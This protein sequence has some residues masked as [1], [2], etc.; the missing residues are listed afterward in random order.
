MHP[1]STCA[2]WK[3]L[4]QAQKESKVTCKIHP[5]DRRHVTAA[6]A[7]KNSGK[8][9][10]RSCK[11]LGHHSL[12]CPTKFAQT[13]TGSATPKTMTSATNL[14]PVLLQTALLSGE[15][16]AKHGVMFDL[17]STDDYVTHELTKRLGFEGVHV[18]LIVEGIAGNK[19]S[20]STMIYTV[21]IRDLSGTFHTIQCYGLNN[22]CTSAAPPRRQVWLETWSGAEAR[23][24]RH[25]S[26][27]EAEQTAPSS[28]QIGREDDTVSRCVWFCVRRFRQKYQF[29]IS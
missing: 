18:K 21:K 27:N 24:G 14:P 19:T 11:E 15:G 25:T 4:T 26:V 20:M 5:F 13:S 10:C 22:I 29:C 28:G 12:L 8:G 23:E 3:A 7:E 16:R 1:M 9:R 2:V 17:C 6:C